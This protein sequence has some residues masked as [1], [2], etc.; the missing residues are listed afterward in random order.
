[1]N[2]Y[3]KIVITGIGAITAAGNTNELWNAITEQKNCL[4][5]FESK[6]IKN[7][8]AKVVGRVT[9][10]ISS[11]LPKKI[12]PFCSRHTLLAA[13]ALYECIENANINS[14]SQNV[15]GLIF[16]STS[17]G[18]DM[19][20][21]SYKQLFNKA[22]DE[23][24]YNILNTIS[25]AGAAQ[26]LS[27]L[28]NLNGFVQGVEAASCS[29]LLT[30]INGANLIKSGICERV[31][32][33]VGEANLFPATILY[34]SRKVRMSGI[35]YSFFGKVS[36]ADERASNDYVIPFGHPQL[37]DR[38]AIAEAGA[39][40]LLE[41]EKAALKRNARIHAEFE[42]YHFSFH[43]DNFHGT[44]NQQLGL[45]RVMEIYKSL[46]FDSA[47]LPITGCYPMDVAT[48]KVCGKYYPNM[49][50][51]SAEAVIGHTGATTALINTILAIKS[52]ENK[53][54]LPTK[55]Y[56]PNS[57]DT[58]C[59]LSPETEIKPFDKI[60]RL[61]IISTGFGGYN[62]SCSIKKYG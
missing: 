59:S 39:V 56:L 53:M 31:F 13:S 37:S 14:F 55:N 24:N 5:V 52:I 6:E 51:F 3:E 62:G 42:Q 20:K 61:L 27:S 45:N 50:A 38:G 33:V 22:F 60:K 17:L 19:M 43:A 8:P 57:K 26:I 10:D 18:Q 1:M 12:L 40:I 15:N 9:K 41:S 58:L 34:Y 47:Y 48:Y 25:N 21:N 28:I 44:D 54:L 49:H 29:G 46:Q 35:S 30:L 2:L 23:A 4:S 7:L 32:C 11:K 36:N 16:G